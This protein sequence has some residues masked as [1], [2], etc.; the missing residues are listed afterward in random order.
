MQK[1]LETQMQWLPRFWNRISD[2]LPSGMPPQA[3]AQLAALNP[4][5]ISL[6]NVRSILGVST[7]R[8]RLVCETA[9]RRGV[10]IKR[11]QV[12]CPDGSVAATADTEADV[13]ATVRCWGDDGDF[14]VVSTETLRRLE[15][16]SFHG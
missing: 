9:V 1:V 2:A 8:A 13:P 6:E 16:Y 3:A 7:A 10:F 11:L 12:L 5:R 14:D 4:E 15:V